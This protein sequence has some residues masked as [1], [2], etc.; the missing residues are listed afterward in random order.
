MATLFESG[1]R[2]SD[3]Y[4]D[5]NVERDLPNYLYETRQEAEA[6]E[7]R[8]DSLPHVARD[9][10]SPCSFAESLFYAVAKGAKDLKIRAPTG[11]EYSTAVEREIPKQRWALERI[12]ADRNRLA[13][14]GTQEQYDKAYAAQKMRY[15]KVVQQ[16]QQLNQLHALI[17]R[18]LAKAASKKWPLGEPRRPQPGGDVPPGH[19]P[20][21]S[22]PPGSRGGNPTFSPD[23]G[24]FPFPA[25]PGRDT[26]GRDPHPSWSPRLGSAVDDLIDLGPVDGAAHDTRSEP[27]KGPADD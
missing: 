1:P 10:S 6:L 26:I 5:R 17:E 24:R 4:R 22:P 20:P 9:G 11:R 8:I 7:V 14:E 13:L 25:G 19:V 2:P 15:E 16:R 21:V 3:P 18:V 27:T 23:A 12:A